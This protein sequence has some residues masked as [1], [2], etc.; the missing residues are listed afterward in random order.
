MAERA[1]AEGSALAVAFEAGASGS[2]N[3]LY[4]CSLA[5]SSPEIYD[6]IAGTMRLQ[7]TRTDGY[8]GDHNNN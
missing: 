7:D 6:R 3:I 4:H 2:M 1:G 8:T 5:F